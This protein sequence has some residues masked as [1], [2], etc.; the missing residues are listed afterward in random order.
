MTN[1]NQNR[2]K[3]SLKYILKTQINNNLTQ[4]LY[5]LIL[6]LYFPETMHSL[7]N[8]NQIFLKL[9]ITIKIINIKTI[10]QIIQKII[11]LNLIT[12]KDL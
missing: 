1:N 9:L 12:W 2:L 3:S 8:F 10:S 4:N 11:P 5:I 6:K 7:L